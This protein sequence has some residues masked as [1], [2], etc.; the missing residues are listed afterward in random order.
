MT[1]GKTVLLASRD[2]GAECRF[3]GLTLERNG[4]SDSPLGSCF[5]EH[6][7]EKVLLFP[8]NTSPHVAWRKGRDVR[9]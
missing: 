3:L 4:A 6:E 1:N 8:G 9:D 2:P 5:S 7:G